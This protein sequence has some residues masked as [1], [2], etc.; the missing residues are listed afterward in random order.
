MESSQGIDLFEELSSTEAGIEESAASPEE[1]DELADVS[2]PKPGQMRVPIKKI[3]GGDA[4]AASSEEEESE[5]EIDTGEKRTEEA[6]SGSVAS[7]ESEGEEG[8]ESSQE[9][10]SSPQSALHLL[11]SALAE[12]GM[13]SS[14]DLAD[15]KDPEGLLKKIG[16]HFQAQIEAKRTEGLN[17]RQKEYL[18]SL[19][20]GIPPEVFH[21][22]QSVIQNL[23]SISSEMIESDQQL[24]ATIIYNDYLDKGFSKERALRLTQQQQKNGSDVEEAKDA[25]KTRIEKE[26]TL[27]Q[28]EKEK[29]K[30]AQLEEQKRIENYDNELKEFLMDE[31]TEVFPGYEMTKNQREKLYE[32]MTKVVAKSKDGKN[33]NE[34]AQMME[35]DPKRINAAINFLAMITDNFK[36]LKGLETKAKSSAVSELSRKLKGNTFDFAMGSGGSG[37]SADSDSRDINIATELFNNL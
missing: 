19:K 8:K 32:K 10:R 29:A 18:E 24:R 6:A 36:N 2:V 28:E 9:E 30:K 4:P 35:K 11:A 20:D 12:E 7:G 17:D 25:L 16:E 15:I 37:A 34:L 14:P 22:R 26:E 13:L 21:E 5:E 27:W 1:I 31:K 23:K 33:L 3:S